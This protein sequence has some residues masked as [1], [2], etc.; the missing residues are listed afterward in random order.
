MEI[1]C[2]GEA[3]AIDQITPDSS[4]Y[5]QISPFL[6]A[7]SQRERYNTCTDPRLALSGRPPVSRGTGIFIW[8]AV[9]KRSMFFVDGF[10]MYHAL[11]KDPAFHKY[12]WLD[13]DALARCFSIPPYED[14]QSVRYF[15][16]YA[17]W[18]SPQ[19][20]SRHKAYVKL[21]KS[22]NVEIVLGRFQKK[23]RKCCA[24]QG[25]GKKFISHEEKLTDVNI[26]VSIVEACVRGQCDI[27]Y[28]VSADNDLVPALETAKRLCSSLA[29]TVLLPPHPKVKTLTD[30]CHKNGYSVVKISD[31]FL[32][33]SQ[34]PDNVTLQGKTY[35]RPPKWR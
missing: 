20:L 31:A 19:A 9:M 8:R 2:Y 30:I 33:R 27:L 10:N 15:T 24:P 11:D 18:R 12:K 13:L 5:V 14:I 26:A 35:Y 6:L 21:L 7:F 29:I 16:A 34:F 22:K 3:V 1:R 28:L 25:C 4:K 17:T 23:D 32:A